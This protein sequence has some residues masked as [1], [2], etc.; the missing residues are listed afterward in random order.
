M[1]KHDVGDVWLQYIPTIL[2]SWRSIDIDQDIKDLGYLEW[3]VYL[4]EIRGDDHYEDVKDSL[5][6]KGWVRPL[7]CDLSEWPD[8]KQKC[9]QFGDGHHRLAVAIDL[10]ATHVP[11]LRPKTTYWWNMVAADSGDWDAGRKP[12]KSRRKAFLELDI[13][14][15]K[16]RSNG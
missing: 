3:M 10:G 6:T 13:P 8:T 12:I 11:I 9:W 7:T 4:N 2:R 14:K 5:L 16:V 1:R 15:F